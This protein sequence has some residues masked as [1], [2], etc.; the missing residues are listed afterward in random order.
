MHRLHTTLWHVWCLWRKY[1]QFR[2]LFAIHS[3]IRW[4]IV[5][6]SG[7]KFIMNVPCIVFS[8]TKLITQRVSILSILQ[9]INICTKSCWAHFG[10]IMHITVT[11]F[12]SFNLFT[13]GS[14]RNF[15]IS[16]ILQILAILGNICQ[17]YL[18]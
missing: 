1:H 3:V 18:L 7:L 4:T 5:H 10:A 12:H 6:L 11:Q 17:I 14:Y 9:D 13:S 15:T 2:Y 16:N 8:D